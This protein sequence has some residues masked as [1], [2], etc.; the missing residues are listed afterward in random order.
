MTKQETP[1]VKQVDYKHALIRRKSVTE[2]REVEVKDVVA[3]I[4]DISGNYHIKTWA[5]ETQWG[6]FMCGYH[7]GDP[8]AVDMMAEAKWHF[9]YKDISTLDDGTMIPKCNMKRITFKE[10]KP[11]MKECAWFHRGIND[12]GTFE[13]SALTFAIG[14]L[15]FI[16]LIFYFLV[17]K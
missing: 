1:R 4:E 16:A 17:T 15:T 9:K 13:W 2:V 14:I 11:Y 6:G 3:H 7:D 12:Y 10:G 5:G 8:Y